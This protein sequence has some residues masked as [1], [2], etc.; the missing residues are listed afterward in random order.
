VTANGTAN[1]LFDDRPTRRMIPAGGKGA[2][3]F[4]AG[5]RIGGPMGVPVRA[6]WRGGFKP[7]ACRRVMG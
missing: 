6:R 4:N 7:K 3:G 2:S 5:I 1:R